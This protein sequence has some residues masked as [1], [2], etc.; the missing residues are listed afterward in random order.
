[1]DQDKFFS[2]TQDALKQIKKNKNSFAKVYKTINGFKNLY[3]S[4]I[5]I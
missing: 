1:M 2:A 5:N 4:K 3:G